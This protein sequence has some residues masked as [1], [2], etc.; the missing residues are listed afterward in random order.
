[1]GFTSR[2]RIS[3][4]KCLPSLTQHDQSVPQRHQRLSRPQSAKTVPSDH[5]SQATDASQET[6]AISGQRT[7]MAPCLPIW[8][9]RGCAKCSPAA[10]L[11]PA[12][13]ATAGFLRSRSPKRGLAL[14]LLHPPLRLSAEVDTPQRESKVWLIRWA[15]HTAQY[16]RCAAALSLCRC[17]VDTSSLYL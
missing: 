13:Q 2:A 16:R 17:T 11:R 7:A 8:L 5:P 10:G 12:E 1:L 4:P 14:F 9:R 3:S 6:E 15:R